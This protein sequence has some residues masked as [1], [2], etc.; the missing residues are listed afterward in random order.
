[1]MSQIGRISTTSAVWRNMRRLP[2]MKKF[3]ISSVIDFLLNIQIACE[4]F[5]LIS[6]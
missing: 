1:M 5:K 6:M 2:D 4:L 3:H